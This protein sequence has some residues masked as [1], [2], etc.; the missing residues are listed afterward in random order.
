MKGRTRV[1]LCGM[2]DAREI[3]VA[4]EA[5]AD[6]IGLILAA[7]PRRLERSRFAALV[8]LVPP[9]VTS[10][11]VLAD[12][13]PDDAAFALAC[14]ATLQFSGHETPETCER[15]AKGARYLKAYH[16]PVDPAAAAPQPSSAPAPEELDRYPGALWLF[17]STVRG[18]LGGTGVTFDW[19]SVAPLARV[20]PVV[21]SG[22]LTAQNVAACVRAVRP[23]AVDVRS[24]VETGDRKDHEKMRAFVRAVREID[25]EA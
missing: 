15:A 10:V 13:A 16:V 1:K 6:A 22:G 25:A 24:G 19:P 4:V 7:S 23:Y 20:R 9:F 12:N 21:V 18:A 5:G 17:D 11:A 3:E 8:R 2:T 14:G